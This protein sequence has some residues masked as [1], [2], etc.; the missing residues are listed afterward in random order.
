MTFKIVTITDPGTIIQYGAE[1]LSKVCKLLSGYDLSTSEPV[2]IATSWTFNDSRLKINDPSNLHT[3]TVTGAA[4]LSLS[5]VTISIPAISTSTDSFVLASQTI[6]WSKVSKTGSHLGDIADVSISSVSTGQVPMWNGSAWA[7]ATPPGAAGGEANT[8]SNAGTGGI[9]II[10]TKS[11]I[12]LPFKSVKANSSMVSITNDAINNNVLVDIV[13]GNISIT[14][15]AQ[16][17]TTTVYNDQANTF[18]AFLQTFGG[19]VAHQNYTDI[20]VI[21]IPTTPAAGIGRL[22]MKQIDSNN[23]GLFV[24]K[25]VNNVITEVQIA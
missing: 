3:Y 13:P 20:S 1:D 21:T 4:G 24:L 22:Y 18:G 14:T 9:G 19:A 8:Y 7:N 25:K 2:T 6:A 11:G 23:D 12:N 5:N 10:L 16:L 17:P 15:K